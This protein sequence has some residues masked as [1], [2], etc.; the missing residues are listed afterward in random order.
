MSSTTVE[1]SRTVPVEQR[2]AFDA[3]LPMPLPEIFT[4]RHGLL[5]PVREVRGQEGVWGRPGQSRT[6]VTTDGGTMREHLVDVDAPHSFS[7][8]LT[9]ITGPV[10]LLVD[11]IDGRWT[12][13]AGAPGTG[14]VVTWRWT[15]HPRCAG[16]VALPLVAV[17]WR[18]YARKALERLSELLTA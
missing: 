6:V 18:G 2:V 8:R 14:T 11:S 9:D 15:L 1:S 3:T 16:A 10:R 17:L 4:R 5:P 12:F 13:V 7:Y